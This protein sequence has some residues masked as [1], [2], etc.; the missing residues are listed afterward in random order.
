MWAKGARVSVNMLKKKSSVEDFDVVQ[1]VLDKEGAEK[2]SDSVRGHSLCVFTEFLEK[3]DPGLKASKSGHFAGLQRVPDPNSGTA[4][5]TTLTDPQEIKKAL[6]AR[7]SERKAEELGDG[8]IDDKTA[9]PRDG[10]DYIQEQA[11]GS[12]VRQMAVDK[13]ANKGVPEGAP[14]WISEAA[15]RLHDGNSAA[16]WKVKA[17]EAET[18]RAEA[19]E[20]FQA[21]AAKNKANASKNNEPGTEASAARRS[22]LITADG[23]HSCVIC[24]L[25]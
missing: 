13:A 1:D 16:A 9:E 19:E 2:R 6:E 18:A 24:N 8:K 21:E 15:V 3:N 14:G 4:L 10:N 17:E 12:L 20:R 23:D 7:T 5:W 22:A 11:A 25:Q